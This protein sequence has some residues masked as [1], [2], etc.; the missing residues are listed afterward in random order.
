MSLFGHTLYGHL[1]IFLVSG[2]LDSRNNVV[3]EEEGNTSLVISVKYKFLL[4][5]IATFVP[6]C[7]KLVCNQHTVEH[8]CI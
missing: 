4:N 6:T 8:Y 7:R 1:V 5:V 2:A 3:Q